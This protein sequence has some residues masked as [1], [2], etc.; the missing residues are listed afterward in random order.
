MSPLI[1]GIVLLGATGVFYVTRPYVH[2]TQARLPWP[3]EF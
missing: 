2:E 1:A 3:L